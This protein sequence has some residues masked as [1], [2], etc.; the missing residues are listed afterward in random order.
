MEPITGVLVLYSRAKV[1]NVIPQAKN[2]KD[3]YKLLKGK[4][5]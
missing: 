5:P 3:S 4:Y 1:V 2:N